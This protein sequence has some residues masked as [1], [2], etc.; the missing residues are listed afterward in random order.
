MRS[1]GLRGRSVWQGCECITQR[2]PSCPPSTALT[3]MTVLKVMGLMTEALR[4]LVAYCSA[5]AIE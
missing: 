5:E 2:W 4:T 3:E 1:S